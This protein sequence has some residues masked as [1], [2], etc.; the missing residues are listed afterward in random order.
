MRLTVRTLLAWIDEVLSPE[1]QQALG[2]KVAG[3]GVAPQL[4]ERIRSVVEHAAVAAPDPEGRGLADDPN[5]VAEFLD[6]VLAG[7]RLESFERVCIESDMHLAEA[8][9]CHRLLAEMARDPQAVEVPGT[10]ERRRWLD[11]AAHQL[12]VDPAA[13]EFGAGGKPVG[14][15]AMEPSPSGRRRR[16]APAAAWIAAAAAVGLLALLSGLLAW[17]L[18]R[19]GRRP[20]E[21]AGEA[22][23]AVASGKPV[24]EPRPSA[25]PPVA[26]EPPRAAADTSAAPPAATLP[27]LEPPAA[28]SRAEPPIAVAPAPAAGEMTSPAQVADEPP[29]DR[30]D[31]RAVDS[32]MARPGQQPRIAGGDALAIVAAPTASGHPAPAATAA[33]PAVSTMPAP[34]GAPAAD[35]A[36]VALA[37]EGGPLLRR[38]EDAGGARWLAVA[39]GAA[40]TDSEDLLVPP[41]SYPTLSIDG[42]MIRLHPNTRAVLG[43]DASGVPRLEVVFGRA[44][45]SGAAAEAAVGVIAGGLCGELSGMLRQPAGIEVVLDRAAGEAPWRRALV[46]AGAAEKVW[47]QTAAAGAAADEPLAGI[48]G[49]SVLA[50]RTTL[51]WDDRDAGRAVVGPPTAEP[52]WMREATAGDRT[53]RAAARGL[54]DALTAAGADGVEPTLRAMAA[55]RRAEDRMI[56][57]ATLALLGEYGELVTLLCDETPQGMLHEGQWTD[58]ESQAVPL[59]IARG[60]NALATLGEAF[61]THGPAGKGEALLALA[62]GFGDHELAAGGDAFLVESLDDGS[63]AVRRY[64]IRRLIEIV[65][66]DERHRTDYRADRPDRLRREGTAWWRAELAQGRIRRGPL[67]AASA[68]TATSPAEPRDDE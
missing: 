48:A 16:R 6:N 40:L 9:A 11:A 18:V 45:V 7:D 25:P 14:S 1:D 21:L 5:N 57:A 28:E 33:A 23:A 50:A 43:R 61:R 66:P 64:A 22:P 30:P 8:A 24:A 44:V 27:P 49:E 41:W 13:L 38:V 20:R 67:P 39:P 63:L 55:G 3:S 59:A 46:H 29:A 51:S 37:G 35:A 4:V 60:D 58:L 12:P 19:S 65:Q 54:A 34:A 32:S 47:R 26:V 62:R 53:R 36:A 31:E 68:P 10:R 17:S 52:S 56:A 42:I 15:P 2:E